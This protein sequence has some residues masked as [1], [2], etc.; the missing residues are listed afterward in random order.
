MFFVF[1]YL[2]IGAFSAMLSSREIHKQ[3]SFFLSFFLGHFLEG[4]LRRILHSDSP[5]FVVGSSTGGVD[6]SDHENTFKG[7]AT[8]L[9]EHKCHVARLLPCDFPVR[10]HIGVPLSSLLRQ[11][12]QVNV[13]VSCEIC[14]MMMLSPCSSSLFIWC[15]D[16]R[17]R[18]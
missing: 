13:E 4:K 3:N 15:F 6:L 1:F 18:V 17:L 12:V 10:C 8:Y 5:F 16:L 11:F 2:H 7:L 14:V 9:R